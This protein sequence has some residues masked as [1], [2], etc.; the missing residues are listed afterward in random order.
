MGGIFGI[1]RLSHILVLTLMLCLPWLG[2]VYAQ[3]KAAGQNPVDV[4]Y[5][6]QPEFRY[7]VNPTLAGKVKT[8]TALLYTFKDTASGREKSLQRK[9]VATYNA[10]G[11]F[12]AS[13]T[14]SSDGKLI[15]KT[16]IKYDYRDSI[17]ESNVFT[18]ENG[19]HA[20]RIFYKYDSAGNITELQYDPYPKLARKIHH[21][22]SIDGR[23]A[24]TLIYDAADS[25]VSKWTYQYDSKGNEVAA[26]VADK[27]GKVLM[28]RKTTMGARKL[29][30][31]GV[32]GTGK[33]KS[34][35][36]YFGVYEGDTL[37][38]ETT[39]TYADGSSM[40]LKERKDAH[41]NVR[42]RTQDTYASN[43]VLVSHLARTTTYTYDDAGNIIA[44]TDYIVEK[45]GKKPIGL[46]E[47]KYELE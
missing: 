46:K 26:A 35:G 16:A 8:C 22:F 37:A 18:A 42:E 43:K 11:H 32:S 15:G 28:T 3:D 12:T 21:S 25:L 5:H 29:K 17:Q 4:S 20:V 44:A 34:Q 19:L 30:G 2:Q 33:G 45:N 27:T 36:K 24:A 40:K 41:G 47:L 13:D 1:V 6:P 7:V 31:E 39:E 14:Y 38:S 9:I 23:E 10:K